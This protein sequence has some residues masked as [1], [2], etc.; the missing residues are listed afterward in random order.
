[1][2]LQLQAYGVEVHSIV[3]D[4]HGVPH[5]E[6]VVNGHLL[7]VITS[8]R[9]AHEV[10]APT[11][12]RG[13]R[14]AVLLLEDIEVP[15]DE[16]VLLFEKIHYHLSL[17]RKGMAD[18]LLNGQDMIEEDFT[19]PDGK[20][21][22]I[23]NQILIEEFREIFADEDKPGGVLDVDRLGQILSKVHPDITSNRDAAKLQWDAGVFLLAPRQV[24]NAQCH[25]CCESC[26]QPCVVWGKVT[27]ARKQ[28]VQQRVKKSAIGN[29]D[30][31]RE[32]KMKAEAAAKEAARVAAEEAAAQMAQRQADKK[33]L[34]EQKRREKEAEQNK[35]E[36]EKRRKADEEEKA[37]QILYGE[38]SKCIYA[39][40]TDYI[41]SMIS[42]A[43]LNQLDNDN[44][45]LAYDVAVTTL[46]NKC[47]S[48]PGHESL[49]KKDFAIVLRQVSVLRSFVC[50]CCLL[51]LGLTLFSCGRSESRSHV[52]VVPIC[53]LADAG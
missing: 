45:V 41:V 37:R 25:Q 49:K 26:T 23:E 16:N 3:V 6:P 51:L 34:A 35:K 9:T 15:G 24:L 17:L 42:T 13:G 5:L 21:W 46:F 31:V 27:K 19:S 43:A 33:T 18:S 7:K 32:T 36:E 52:T 4:R 47:G 8:I 40:V 22:F 12:P 28:E 11:T 50:C 30:E 44:K 2:G 29:K 38:Q 20:K 14:E 10:T 39:A 1:M 48:H 53:V